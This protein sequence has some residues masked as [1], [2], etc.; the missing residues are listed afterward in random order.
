MTKIEIEDYFE[1]IEWFHRKYQIEEIEN[2]IRV[3]YGHWPNT[4]TLL[5]D[6]GFFMALDLRN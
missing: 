1:A 5:L 3:M 2:V 6:Q 4:T